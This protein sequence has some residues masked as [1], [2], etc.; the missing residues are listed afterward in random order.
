[1][2]FNHRGLIELIKTTWGK[3]CDSLIFMGSI[4][5]SQPLI[6]LPV[7]DSYSNLWGKTA[8]ALKYIYDN[9]LD[10]A[11]WF[12]KADDDTYLILNEST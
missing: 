11:D 12:F 2:S 6:A 10:D 3:R 8:R 4:N 9:H 7:K 5:S 1:M